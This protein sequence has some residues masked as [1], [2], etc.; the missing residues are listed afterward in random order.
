MPMTTRA[1]WAN[2]VSPQP[3]T[4]GIWKQQASHLKYEQKTLKIKRC[5][6]GKPL[7][8]TD[9]IHWGLSGASSSES[10]SWTQQR[11]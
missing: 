10:Q 9:L 3:K 4:R 8:L 7:T 6:E 1:P 2:T 5:Q 11:V